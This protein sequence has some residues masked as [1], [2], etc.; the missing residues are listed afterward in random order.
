M[1][2]II[3]RVSRAQVSV[4]DEHVAEIGVGML[5]LLGV[6]HSDTGEQ[7]ARLA[8]KIAAL[9]IF[10]DS[11]GKMNLDISAI[12]GG[13]LCISQFTLYGDARRGNRPSFEAAAAGPQAQPLY[14]QF[15]S[16]IEKAGVACERGRFGADMQ[17][18]LVNDGPVTL[19]LDTDDLDRP[20]HA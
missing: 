5:V 1:R 8:K 4:G 3:Q 15:C 20:R 10:E 6:A 9:R 12:G 14:E 2:A 19:I 11:D 18:E 13:I 16:E 7:A 17:V